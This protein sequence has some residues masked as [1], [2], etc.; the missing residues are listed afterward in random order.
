MYAPDFS[1]GDEL[2][3]PDP[4]GTHHG[5][6][7]DFSAIIGP[8]TLTAD[9][10]MEFDH[11]FNT[12]SGFDGGVMEVALG[13]PV[14]NATPFAD[15]VTT[16]DLGNHM[17]QNGYTGKLDGT[18]EG[19]VILSPLQGRRA[20]T[21]SRG[22]GSHEDFAASICRGGPLNPSGLPVYIRFRMT[23]DA[24]STP[25]VQSGWYIDNV[26]INGLANC[27]LPPP[28]APNVTSLVS[29]ATANPGS[30]SGVSQY[31]LTIKNVSTQAIYAPLR[32]RSPASVPQVVE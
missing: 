6:M 14:F 4:A 21:G 8:F 3:A 20:F 27:V 10:I 23:S 26:S 18:L 1:P 17:I 12:E 15:N 7:S 9:S 28:P 5:A 32:L 30:S 16:F 22:L 24:A 2:G 19:A 25:G 11:L 13:A 31:D 29:L